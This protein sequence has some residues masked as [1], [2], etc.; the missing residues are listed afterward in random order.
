MD[1][2]GLIKVMTMFT[3]IPGKRKVKLV[4]LGVDNENHKAF[5]HLVEIFPMRHP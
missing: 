1:S 2:G 4:C 5:G 3:G